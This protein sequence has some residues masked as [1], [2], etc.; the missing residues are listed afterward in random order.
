MA[1]ITGSS[2]TAKFNDGDSSH[3]FTL[4]AHATTTSSVNYTWPPAD[5]TTGQFLQTNSSGVL[6]WASA[7][8]AYGL[9]TM[10]LF[11]WF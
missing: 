9:N 6:T 8:G 3:N 5:G 4:A 1:L 7:G 10:V 11:V 2:G